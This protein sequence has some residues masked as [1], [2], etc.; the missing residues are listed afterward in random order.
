MMLH[1]DNDSEKNAKKF[2]H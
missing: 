1:K 2:L